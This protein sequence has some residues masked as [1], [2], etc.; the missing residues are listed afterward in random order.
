VV[1][2]QG[3]RLSPRAVAQGIVNGRQT[4]SEACPYQAD[5]AQRQRKSGARVRKRIRNGKDTG[6]QR[7]RGSGKS[8][9][10][11]GHGGPAD[12]RREQ[13]ATTAPSVIKRLNLQ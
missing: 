9:P 11:A 1:N 2:T 7:F 8:R 6:T 3:K 12:W 10:V 4:T 13:L 5:A